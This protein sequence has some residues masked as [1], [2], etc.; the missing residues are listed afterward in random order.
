MTTDG[1]ELAQTT[2]YFDPSKPEGSALLDF[3]SDLGVYGPSG[4]DD[5]FVPFYPDIS[6][7]VLVVVVMSCSDFLVIKTEALLRLAQ[8]RK[9]EDLQW[10]EWR[11]YATRV[12][13]DRR[14]TMALWVSGP[15]VFSMTRT[16]SGQTSIEVYDFSARAYARYMKTIE[17]G[18]AEEFEPWIT[19]VLPWWQID[20]IISYGC[21]NSITFVLVRSHFSPN[22][23]QTNMFDVRILTIR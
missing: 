12:S 8:E 20:V 13:R 7:R 5:L 2:F 23:P 17:D 1:G 18:M 9:G 6:Q 11:V 10:G 15:L 21:Y 22:Q 4:G 3:A 16:Q 19:H 14:E